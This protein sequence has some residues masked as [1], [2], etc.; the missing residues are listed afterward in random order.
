MRDVALDRMKRSGF[1]TTSRPF[2]GRERE[3]AELRAAFAEAAA[4]KG[5]CVLVAG[6]LGVGKTRLCVELSAH[7]EAAGALVAWGRCPEHGSSAAYRPWLQIFRALLRA[8]ALHT[9]NP[10]LAELAQSM[11]PL[12]TLLP[13]MPAA[14]RL[15]PDQARFRLHDAATLLLEDAAAARPLVLVFDDIHDA[16][17]GSL[18]LLHFV[19]RELHRAPLLLLGTYRDD[20]ARSGDGNDLIAGD[21]ARES[22][23]V[24]LR[25]L[26]LE[27][28]G[29]FIAHLT[30]VDVA[31]TVIDAVHRATGGNPYYLDEVV[32]LAHAEGRLVANDPAALVGLPVPDQV[33]AALRRRLA[34]LAAESRSILSLAA[35]LGRTF[36]PQLLG[37]LA[38]SRPATDALAEARRIGVLE[39]APDGGLAFTNVLLRDGLYEEI[40][41]AER[42]A[43]HERI[44]VT[45]AS[46]PAVD[47][48]LA[49]QLA[50]HAALACA[51]LETSAARLRRAREHCRQAGEAAAARLAHVDAVRYFEQALAFA[52]REPGLPVAVQAELLLE[53]GNCAWNAADLHASAAANARAL[54]VARALVAAGDPRGRELLAR[55]ALGLGGRQQRA[56]VAFEPEVVAALEEGLA[57]LGEAD[58]ALRARLQAR[59]A[60][61][62]YSVPDSFARRRRL[63]GEA[64]ALVRT[65]DDIES[66]IAVLNDTR[67]ALWA[68]D[69]T[70]TRLRTTDELIELATRA[71]DRER[72]I[73]EHAWRLVDLFELGDHSRAW[74]E[75]QTYTALATELRLPWYDWYV[76]RFH[77]LFATIEG[78][79]AE[80]EEYANQ[81]LAAARR[82]DHSDALLIYGVSLMSLRTLQGRLDEIEP[83]LQSF[84]AQY[85]R[86]AA[87]RYAL[88]YILA[89]QGRRDSAQVE[90]DRLA[91]NDFADLPGDYM[92]LAAIAYLAE[93]SH[94][95]GD[96]RRAAL[97]YDLLAP[98]AERFIVVGYGVSGLGSAAR[99]LGLLAATLGR[100]DDAVRHLEHALE[101]NERLGAR[102]FAALTRFDLAQVLRS[103]GGA[104]AHERASRLLGEAREQAERLGMAGLLRRIGSVAAAAT[105]PPAASAA[106]SLRREGEFWTVHSAG[107]TFRLRHVRGLEYLATLLAHPGRSFHVADLSGVALPGG[108]AGAVLDPA[109]KAA[110]RRRLE[111]LRERAAEAEAGNDR[112]TAARA[113][114]EIEALAD[115]LAQAVGLGGRDRRASADAERVRIAVTKAIRI[116]ERRIAE[117]DP[118]LGRYVEL[119]V[120]TGMF[121]EFT[122]APGGRPIDVVNPG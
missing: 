112:E 95:V 73:G 49:F 35:V 56:H 58:A 7:A 28:T 30:G 101:T 69:T 116:A 46:Q 11:P 26:G 55:A 29:E 74:A 87:W 8:G 64:V 43:Q 107:R 33:R 57:A 12:L 15:D 78:R 27:P 89:L 117:H 71:G 13:G 24:L 70:E 98:Y 121:C 90:L 21:L 41:A 102:P 93:V 25:G 120:Q 72:L 105:A 109:A 79:F 3:L 110:Y 32:R 113:R 59:L 6:E 23:R 108:D 92:R 1:P 100:H 106:A 66:R 94:A 114:E 60:Y 14:E 51:P 2:V 47:P 67:W 63:C 42:A 104:G 81:A 119:T 61:A 17:D 115:P 16:D 118:E 54:S 82:V 83:A 36:D 91:A 48:D 122:P 65:C 85:P 38:G 97:L 53:I 103:G 84:A 52:E 19:A 86:L 9:D 4:G 40:P 39:A 37:T 62:L 18:R 76:G 80:A 34:P 22:R 10:G 75:L 88:A 77:A 31:P 44:A 96:A 68:P 50:H 111:A 99:P 45:L 5:G 20:A